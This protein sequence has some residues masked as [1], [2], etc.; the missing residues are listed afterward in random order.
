M[1]K[2]K[3]IL[4]VLVLSLLNACKLDIQPTEKLTVANLLSLND[5]L[6]V[7]TAGN[8]ALLKDVLEFRGDENLNNSYV[9]HMY[10][11]S[12]FAAD[13]VMYTQYS[14]DPL[15]LVFTRNHVA[16]QDNSSY[17]WFMAYKLILGTNLL[18]ENMG[19][20]ASPA[21]DQMLGENYFLRAMAQFDLL[22]FFAFPYTHGASNLGIILRTGTSEP[23]S[24]A[25]ATVGE[26]YDQVVA[27]LLKAIELMNAPRGVEY[28]SKEAAQALLSRVYLYMEKNQLALDYANDVITSGASSLASQADYVN[29]F[30]N[31]QNS[32]ESI[33][34][35]KH[36]PPMDYTGKEG[37]IG[38]MY[39]DDGN[40]GGW[41]EVFVSQTFLDLIQQ[42]PEDVRNDLIQIT[43]TKKNGFPVRYILK[44]TGQDGFV[45]LTSPQYLRLSEMYLN[46]AEANAKIG[47]DQSALDDV[48]VI[49]SRAGLSGAALYT[50]GN[51]G[52]RSV[53]DIVLE[54][55]RLELA[56]EGHRSF[57]QYR[58]KRD[59]DRSYEGIH[60]ASG[61]T[62]QII[63]FDDNRN[64][65]F[66]P[67]GELNTNPECIQNN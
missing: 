51:L 3:F 44:F 6:E 5:G 12:E 17:F 61:E 59:M 20:G 49:R 38:S 67:P 11:M 19:E 32:S 60:L 43:G 23:Q 36:T 4:A 42:H 31:T 46:R 14:S 37:S 48:N 66:I 35:I 9:R 54:E 53:L 24:K 16:A 18:I 22:K 55:R 33:F 41:G 47:N 50:L 27:D 28:A 65:F 30:A 1:K 21:S 56:Y 26:S 58:N 10:Q 45:N 15:Y 34:I 57:D 7:A 2:G 25:R 13:N 8:Y 63:P 29:N 52:G 62:T 64:I 39:Y 40:N